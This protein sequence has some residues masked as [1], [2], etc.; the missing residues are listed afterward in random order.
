LVDPSSVLEEPRISANLN[1]SNLDG[2]LS[3]VALGQDGKRD[4]SFEAK[5]FDEKK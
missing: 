1:D 2:Q 5:V 3:S 4:V